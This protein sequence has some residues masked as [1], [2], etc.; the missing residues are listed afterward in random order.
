ME[1]NAV[2]EDF[3]APKWEK[4]FS[5]EVINQPENMASLTHPGDFIDY[6]ND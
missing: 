4:C 3:D 2:H 1:A 5:I 6:E